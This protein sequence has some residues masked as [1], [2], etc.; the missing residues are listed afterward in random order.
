VDEMIILKWILNERNLSMLT[1]L[2]CINNSSWHSR[3][4]DS[5]RAGRSGNPIPVGERLDRRWSPPSLGRNG[6]RVIS[7]LKWPG[8]DVKYPPLSSAE[9]KGSV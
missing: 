7:G 8:R 9:I 6:Y 5:L 4:S 3:Y 1:E 2:F